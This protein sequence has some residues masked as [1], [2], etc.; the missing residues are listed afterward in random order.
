MRRVSHQQSSSRNITR[1]NCCRPG[2]HRSKEEER[3]LE[4]VSQ[5]TT[6]QG[7]SR[8]TTAEATGTAAA[9]RSSFQLELVGV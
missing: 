4:E 7:D 9:R 8:I 3:V 1:S 2:Q 6:R 5:G